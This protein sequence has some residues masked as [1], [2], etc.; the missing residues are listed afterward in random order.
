M[1]KQILVPHLFARMAQ[2]IKNAPPTMSSMIIHDYGKDPYHILISCLLSLRTRDI[3]T[4]P[5]SKE[6]FKHV[7]TPYE[8]LKLSVAQLEKI[9]KPLGFYKRKA[10]IL[11]DVSRALIDYFHGKVPN[12]EKELLAIKHVGRKTANLVLSMAF[13]IPAICV[14]THVHRIANHLGLV[15]TKTP[16]QTEIALKKIVPQKYWSKINDV[17]V[18]WG[19]NVCKAN[20]KM[21]TCR[22][23]LA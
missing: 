3:V 9:L 18:R 4:Y 20:M 7:C 23:V 2:Q 12:T 8:M 22:I 14:D 11:H 1:K 21:C 19:Q 13:D 5:V 6:L 17:F 16:E 15:H 10:R